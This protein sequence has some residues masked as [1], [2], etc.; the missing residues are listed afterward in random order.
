MSLLAINKI[1]ITSMDFIHDWISSTENFDSAFIKENFF[2]GS[3]TR[4]LFLTL[5]I[6]H[7]KTF[8]TGTSA[9]SGSGILK[10]TKNIE[11]LKKEYEM[12]FQIEFEKKILKKL[13]ELNFK[14]INTQHILKLIPTKKKIKN[15]NVDNIENGSY[16]NVIEYMIFLKAENEQII[17]DNIFSY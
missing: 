8:Y 7:Q 5:D 14:L 12:I 15:K 10:I 17:T 13:K 9:C 1:D 11:K 2:A 16:F 4:S 6:Y 3:F